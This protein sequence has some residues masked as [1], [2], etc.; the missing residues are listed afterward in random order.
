MFEELHEEIRRALAAEGQA[1][2][3]VAE[4]DASNLPE[5][6]ASEIEAAGFDL[7]A[8][9]QRRSKGML[10][11]RRRRAAGF[12]RRNFRRW[13]PAFDQIDILWEVAEEIGREFD[14]AFRPRAALEQDYLFEALTTLHGR[15]LLVGAEAI[16]L[17]HHNCVE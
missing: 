3:I 17:M 11:D 2:E 15:G 14:S 12:Q 9:L 6:I 1:T 8:K 4:L 10:R 16:Q 5:E 13:R 7:S